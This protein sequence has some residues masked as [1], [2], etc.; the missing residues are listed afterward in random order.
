[1]KRWALRGVVLL[2][3]A[4]TGAWL[5]LR[6]LPGRGPL[7]WDESVHA[8]K[9]LVM[10]HDLAR[11]D[12]L[13]FLFDSYRQVL[14]PPLHYWYLAVAYLAAGASVTTAAAVTLLFFLL[15][16]GLLYLAGGLLRPG[17]LNWA[18]AVAAL[19]W[20]TSPAL[21]GF[22]TQ[23][24][25]EIPGLAALCLA[26]LVM[27][28]LLGD[29]PDPREYALLGAAIALTFFIRIPY[30]IVLGLA[31]A[32]W[33]L[34]EVRGRFWQLWNRRTF[35][36]LLPLALPLAV[37]FAYLPKLPATLSWLVN[38]PDGVDEPYGVEGWLFY[39]L[40]LVR[41]AGSPWLFA[42]YLAGMVYAVVERRRGPRFLVVLVLVQLILGE[43]HQNKQARYL[44]PVFP[45]WYLLAGNLLVGIGERLVQRR[46]EAAPWATAGVAAL[47]ALQGGLFMRTAPAPVPVDRPDAVTAF[48]VQWLDPGTRTL[49]V[50]SMDLTYPSPP[51]LDWR[52]AAE[53]QVLGVPWAGSAA[54][55]EEGRK[56]AGLVA[57]LPLPA[58]A[59]A[60][61][62]RVLTA[63]DQPSGLRTLYLGLPLRAA[64]SPNAKAGARFIVALVQEQAIDQVLLV[65]A[66]QAQPRYPR[67]PL[68]AALEAAG[69]RPVDAATF[70]D[71]K[72]Q[73]EVYQR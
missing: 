72:M 42:L 58:G 22:A 10:A 46:P 55:I 48:I 73:V 66:T 8:F 49:V 19:L 71:V 40:A 9:G 21:L 11:G 13:S 68:A 43:F 4:G 45:A 20:L 52:L 47:L 32:V 23:V 54:Q 15:G 53:Q 64:Y 63:Y 61:L 31:V 5:A 17:R 18:G 60:A 65:T 41:S 30:G 44:F 33:L 7:R 39:P 34:A 35:Y 69:W 3:I 59:A 37:W 6:L 12:G 27:L 16:A 56:L 57:K 24:M 70:A 36:L 28:K 25:L 26:L 14:Y 62:Q 67:A 51:L 2:L 50:G 1:M 29:N 38:Y